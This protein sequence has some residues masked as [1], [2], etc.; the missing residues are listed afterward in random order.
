MTQVTLPTV[1]KVSE[2]LMRAADLLDRGWSRG[3]N[4]RMAN[5]NACGVFSPRANAYS[6]YG[7]LCAVL[8]PGFGDDK[9]P[10]ASPAWRLIA[11]RAW[12]ATPEHARARMEYA[13]HDLN[14]C[15]ATASRAAELFREW[16]ISK[17]WGIGHEQYSIHP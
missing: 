8:G 12:E 5:G 13:L 10:Q 3:A 15:I 14:D 17:P 16:A 7:A 11:L 4:A 9:V 2:V 6:M 1:A